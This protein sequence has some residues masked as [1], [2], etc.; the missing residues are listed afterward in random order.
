MYNAYQHQ[1]L[2]RAQENVTLIKEINE[3]RRELKQARTRINDLEAAL[4]LHRKGA[5]AGAAG[6]PSIAAAG[7][8]GPA[9]EQLELLLGASTQPTSANRPQ[10]ERTID[11]QERI[12]EMQRIEIKKLRDQLNSA[13]P[14]PGAGAL[15][16]PLAGTPPHAMQPLDSLVAWSMQLTLARSITHSFQYHY[17]EI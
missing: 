13:P 15:L 17:R 11:E 1:V 12:I 5:G 10:L 6:V 2:L 16:P 7:L 14:P 3:L 9:L 4:G 8:S